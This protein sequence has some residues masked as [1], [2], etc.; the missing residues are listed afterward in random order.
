MLGTIAHIRPKVVPTAPKRRKPGV[1]RK[2]QQH[3]MRDWRLAHGLSL[4]EM[5]DRI[6]QARGRKFTT[7]G[8]LSRVET[9][10]LQYRQDLLETFAEVLGTT[11]ALLLTRKPRDPRDVYADLIAELPNLGVELTPAAVERVTRPMTLPTARVGKRQR[12]KK[13]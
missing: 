13:P 4:E 6:N 3:F 5:A 8:T 1:R 2:R 9:G 11:P 12:P 10:A 7:V